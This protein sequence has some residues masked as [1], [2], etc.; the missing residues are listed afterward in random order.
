M[1]LKAEQKSHNGLLNFT[2]GLGLCFL[3]DLC[4]I[5]LVSVCLCLVLVLKNKPV[6]PVPT[7]NYL[8]NTH[9]EF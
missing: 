3:S 7:E 2:F 1:A 9:T 4:R 6:T 5:T 8:H